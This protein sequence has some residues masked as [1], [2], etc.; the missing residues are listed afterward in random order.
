[1]SACDPTRDIDTSGP[2]LEIPH[3]S[4]CLRLELVS[5][6]QLLAAVRGMV[7]GVALRMGFNDCDASHISLAVDEV[8][9]NVMRHGYERRL[10]GLIDVRVWRL[11][12]PSTGILIVVED[13]GKQVDPSCFKGRELDDLRPGGLGVHIIREVMDGCRFEPRDGAGMRTVLVKWL[14][15]G[16][17]ESSPRSEPER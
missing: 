3:S 2:P 4:P 7:D 16:R 14:P 13:R 9:A 1:M 5:D 8:L 10:D 17:S 12:G 11:H 6:P 15:T